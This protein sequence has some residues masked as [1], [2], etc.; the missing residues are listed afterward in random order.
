MLLKGLLAVLALFFT[1][2]AAVAILPTIVNNNESI[3]TDAA[4]D[5]GKTCTPGEDETTCSFTLDEP[6]EYA[7]TSQMT[8]TETSPGSNDH[9][10]ATTVGTDRTTLTVS[11]LTSEQAYIFSVAYA[12]QAANVDDGL[13]DLL[14]LMPLL[15]ILGAVTVPIIA[16]V[17]VFGLSRRN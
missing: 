12:A 3:R 8:V 14:G 11:G 2:Y 1:I 9:T 6:H 13:N 7:D 10:D 15:L 4:T 17:A 5:T 16:L